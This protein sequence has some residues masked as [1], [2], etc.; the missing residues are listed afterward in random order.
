M[1]SLEKYFNMLTG[2]FYGG[3]LFPIFNGF[4][5]NYTNSEGDLLFIRSMWEMDRLLI[6]EGVVEPNFVKGIFQKK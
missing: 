3:I 2:F 5:Q 6:A 1:A 4:A